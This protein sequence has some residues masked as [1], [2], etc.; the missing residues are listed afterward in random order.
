[1]LFLHTSK[2]HTHTCRYSLINKLLSWVSWTLYEV[3]LI[4]KPW[5]TCKCL[6]ISRSI[7]CHSITTF[8]YALHLR[9]NT[10]ESNLQIC[11]FS[12]YGCIGYHSLYTLIKDLECFCDMYDA[13]QARLSPLRGSCTEQI[14]QIALLGFEYPWSW[15]SAEDLLRQILWKVWPQ[16]IAQKNHL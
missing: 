8:I 2:I 10:V 12:Y 1:M 9:V 5:S 6:S 7:S 11:K 14:V 16:L 15:Q 13:E 4:H 3:F